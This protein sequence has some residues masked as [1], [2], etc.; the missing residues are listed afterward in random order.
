MGRGERE[1]REGKIAHLI[2]W[3]NSSD[4]W[5]PSVSCNEFINPSNNDPNQLQ[6]GGGRHW[7]AMFNAV[8]HLHCIIKNSSH[9]QHFV[10]E[11]LCLMEAVNKSCHSSSQECIAGFNYSCARTFPCV[12]YL[13][14]F[15]MNSCKFCTNLGEK[16]G[17]LQCSLLIGGRKSIQPEISI[18]RLKA[19]SVTAACIPSFGP[20]NVLKSFCSN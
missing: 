8:R 2:G 9:I 5:D 17:M 16:F 18:E 15:L 12:L 3:M 7:H 14:S 6:M 19:V 20:R 10:M 4:L 1:R 13:V 11:L